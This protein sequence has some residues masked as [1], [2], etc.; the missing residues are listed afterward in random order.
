MIDLNTYLAYIA[1]CIVI[2]IVPGPS[3]T[4]IFA[5]SLRAGTAAGLMNVAGTQA[6]LLIM[7]GVL[8]AGLSVVV[9]NLATLF[10]AVRLVGAAYLVWLGIKMWRSDGTLSVDAGLD[11]KKTLWGYFLQGLFVLLSNPK[12][13][14]FFGAFIPQFIDPARNPL[15]QTLVLGVTFM[16]VAT[17]LDSAYAIVA[18]RAG[19]LL[20]RHK[21]RI[22]ERVS[23]TAL[24]GGGIWLALSRR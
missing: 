5:N 6:G 24:V 22:M 19:S 21:I 16:L 15:L 23:G 7:L 14:L 20:S 10:D 9:N 12:V 18:G 1:A 2:V 17:L 3:V 13:L 11:T 4:L 8:A